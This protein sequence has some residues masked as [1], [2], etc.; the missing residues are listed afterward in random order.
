MGHTLENKSNALTRA[1]VSEKV[2][3]RYGNVLNLPRQRYIDIVDAFFEEICKALVH[4]E[5]VK[6]SSFGSFLVSKKNTRIG[7]NPKTGKE[8]EIVAR[9][10]I[11]FRPSQ[12]L[13]ARV[14]TK[15]S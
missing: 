1:R 15:K 9:K 3:Q 14:N 8:A 6:I 2:Q 7:R 10:V 13:K 12:Y 4:E 11:T 5:D